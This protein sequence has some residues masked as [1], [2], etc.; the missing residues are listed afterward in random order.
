[1]QI[2]AEKRFVSKKIAE[3]CR[4]ETVAH[5]GVDLQSTAIGSQ[6]P[7]AERHFELVNLTTADNL[8]FMFRKT[9]LLHSVNT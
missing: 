6:F 3:N 8:I 2:D 7:V 4:N 5:F 9:Y 1:M